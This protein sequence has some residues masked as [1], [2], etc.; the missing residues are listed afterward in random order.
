MSLIDISVSGLIAVVSV[1]I[2]IQYIIKS[3]VINVKAEQ[4]IEDFM[5]R[6]TTDEEFIKKIYSV[7]AIFAQGAVAGS[8]INPRGGK[9][10]ITDLISQ[11]AGRFLGDMFQRKD[12]GAS[13]AP[14]TDIE[15][16]NRPLKI[17]RWNQ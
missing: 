14:V 15:P 7:G 9:F 11:I 6:A 3:D 17:D 1:A 16:T 12:P 10:K 5:Q 4:I 13:G 2:A 8:G